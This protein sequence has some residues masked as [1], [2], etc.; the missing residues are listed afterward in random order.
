MTTTCQPTP[1]STSPFG[2]GAGPNSP[3][4]DDAPGRAMRVLV[5]EDEP[6]TADSMRMLLELRGYE[7]AVAHTGSAAITAA[8]GLRPD[9]VLCDLALPGMDG[10]AV[11]EALRRE[12]DLPRARLIAVSGYS[13]DSALCCRPTAFERHLTKP[14]EPEELLDTLRSCPRFAAN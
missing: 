2:P 4:T 13:P 11:A 6:D 12:S 14:V 1:F 7:V 3:P 9:V 10:F 5:V 8:R